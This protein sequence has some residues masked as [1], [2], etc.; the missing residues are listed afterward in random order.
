[1]KPFNPRY[2]YPFAIL[3]VVFSGLLL[4]F[5]YRLL[6]ERLMAANQNKQI[7]LWIFLLMLGYALILYSLYERIQIAQTISLIYFFLSNF[8]VT[9]YWIKKQYQEYLKKG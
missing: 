7:W 9:H 3:T 5:N 8:I 2:I 4:T 6:N 1:M